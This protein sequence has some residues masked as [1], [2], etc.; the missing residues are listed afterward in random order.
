MGICRGAGST[1]ALMELQIALWQRCP[2]LSAAA[3][4]GLCHIPLMSYPTLEILVR[5]Q[6]ERV[7]P[8]EGLSVEII[9]Q[10]LSEDE[11]AF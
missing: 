8:P 4:S 3:L 6:A 9:L 11:N 7:W 5:V 10:D 2:S 1:R